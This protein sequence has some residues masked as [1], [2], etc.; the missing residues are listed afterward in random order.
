MRRTLVLFC[1]M[2][3]LFGAFPASVGAQWFNAPK[4]AQRLPVTVEAYFG[5]LRPTGTAENYTVD[6]YGGRVLWRA[7][8]DPV[9]SPI[10][11]RAL[12]GPFGEYMDAEARGFSSVHVGAHAE[13]RVLAAPLGGVIDPV[14]SLAAGVLRTSVERGFDDQPAFA[15][16]TNASVTLTPAVGVRLGLIR[17][18]ALRADARDMIVFRGNDRHN[19]QYTVGIGA[20][21]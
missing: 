13:M 20:T 15:G 21:F 1:S 3:V 12:F 10:F 14:A 8:T 5:Q 19:W 4:P 6:L 18:V 7:A 9:D 17:G 16:R 2:C 11:S